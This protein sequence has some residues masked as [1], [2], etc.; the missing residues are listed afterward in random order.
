VAEDEAATW[1]GNGSQLA[2]ASNR[3]GDYEIYVM[4]ADG[5]GQ[6][7]LTDNAAE[8]RWPAWAQ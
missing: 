7:A 2:F 8:D 3:D 4:N 6:S 1:N 5:S